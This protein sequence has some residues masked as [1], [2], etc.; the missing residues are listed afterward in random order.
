MVL[1][2]AILLL[3]AGCLTMFSAFGA[4][5]DWWVVNRF[6]V[7]KK[8]EDFQALEAAWDPS[9][10]ASPTIGSSGFSTKLEKILPVDQTA[11]NPSLGQYDKD[12]LFP[13][14][15]DVQAKLSGLAPGTQCTWV[16]NDAEPKSS[17]CALSPKLAVKAHEAF[18]LSV[19]PSGGEPMRAHFPAIAERL[20]VSLGDSFASG[21]GNPDHP[22]VLKASS[23]SQDWFV[24]TRAKSFILRGARWWDEA[25]HRSLLSWPA[26][27]AM[28]QAIQN[29]REVV[30]F[31][32]FACS[33]AEVYDGVLR[34]QADPPGGYAKNLI[35]GNYRLRDGGLGYHY[36]SRVGE[37]APYQ[38]YDARL[39]LSQQ[40]ALALLL[41]PD[42]KVVQNAELRSPEAESGTYLGQTYFGQVDLYGCTSGK[43]KIDSLLVSVG[44]NDVAF[45]GVVKW[46]IVPDQA[47]KTL[48]FPF[49]QAALGF[50]LNS[51]HVVAPEA[52]KKGIDALPRIYEAFNK[53][54]HNL[55]VDP[56]VVKIL[57]YPDPTAG[58][59][60]NLTA[61]N[62][63]TRDGNAPFQIMV[64]E[65][66]RVGF[67]PGNSN[68][69]FG[70]NPGDFARLN[71]DFVQP[72][73]NAQ[74]KA[75][76]KYGWKPIDSQPA[77][78]TAEEKTGYCGVSP[79][80]TEK[81]CSMGDRVK[82]WTQHSY[83]TAPP[84]TRLSD[85]DAY[86]GTRMRGMRYGVDALLAGVGVT[87]SGKI[88]TDWISGSAHPTANVHA[89]IAD[90]VRERSGG[91]AASRNGG[92]SPLSPRTVP[93]AP[94][95]SD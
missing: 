8:A 13:D 66:T 36:D 57:L 86:D 17:D 51:M 30:Q 42:G 75:A 54:L 24:E 65:K 9:F 34:A 94:A 27:T 43:R 35:E 62:R 53:S 93:A 1:R 2:R 48:T 14:T 45:A 32:S 28:A 12:F 83:S 5:L 77:F 89:R 18:N 29:P 41:C 4:E 22:A 16:I 21:E 47:R 70:I 71:Q 55:G 63:R 6:P 81:S 91:A 37:M 61:C 23:A 82:W 33:G 95:A 20:I 92:T 76:S 25:C 10:K 67:L 79:A 59:G 78:E 3:A 74:M 11:W 38:L 26:L 19:T 7:F 49:K 40:H 60:D 46:L 56:A 88:K 90:T 84:L 85:F 68:F 50:L 39:K 15:H 80:C 31:A 58:A 87:N 73:R 72:L 69:L 52:A 44:G 64:R